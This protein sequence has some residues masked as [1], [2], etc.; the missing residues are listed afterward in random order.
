VIAA[1]IDGDGDVDAVA[2]S[3][4]DDTVAW[5]E[6]D[7]TGTFT[8]HL[9]DTGADG[10]YGLFSVDINL[11]GLLDILSASRDARELAI[12]TQTRTHL[13]TVD[14]GSSIVISSALLRAE[15]SDDTPSGLT[16]T[17]TAIPASGMLELGGSAVSAGDTFTQQDI[18]DGLLRYTHDDVDESPDSFDFTLADGGEDGTQ[19]LFGRFSFN[20]PGSEGGPLVELPM[21]EGVGTIA[22]DVSG[23]GNDGVLVNG[24]G[25][26][27]STGDGSAFAVRFDGVDDRIDLGALDVNG[28]GLTLS[29]T[30]NADSYPGSSNDPRLISKAT[31]IRADEHVFML[32]TTAVGSE[33]RLRAR[34]RHGGSVTTLIANSG[35]LV[36]G[37]WYHAAVTYDGAS[38]LMYL[39]GVAVGNALFV[40]AIDVDPTVP[41]AIGGQPPG[42][43][44]RYFDGL[45]DDVRILS[46]AMSATEVAEIAAGV[47]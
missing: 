29:A 45:I 9:V 10:A 47:N 5:Y 19:P 35:S 22:G 23:Q 38:L 7:G 21:D 14:L 44:D 13:V 11:D 39:D 30:F 27:A 25:F 17:M 24:A 1:D 8:G 43:G 33:V 41:V 4:S 31:G 3:V 12:H 42:A 26:E 20:V 32:G 34:V 28:S 37:E 2:A 46:R 36:T 15:D 16:Y 6:N 18:D 40:G